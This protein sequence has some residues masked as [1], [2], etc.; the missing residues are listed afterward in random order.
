MG[1]SE[2]VA[3]LRAQADAL[4]A[5]AEAEEAHAA[6]IEAFRAYPDEDRRAS[7]RAASEGLAAARQEYRL[8]REAAAAA[9]AEANPDTVA[10]TADLGE[11]D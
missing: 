10:G 8:E 11:V 1:T 4:E 3:R 7:Y 5:I 2:E 9:D 6:A